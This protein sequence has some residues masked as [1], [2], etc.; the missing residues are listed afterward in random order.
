MKRTRDTLT[1]GTGDVNPQLMTLPTITLPGSSTAVKRISQAV[2]MPVNRGTCVRGKAVVIEVLKVFF[3]MPTPVGDNPA[4]VGNAETQLFRA[5]LSTAQITTD[6]S[7]G[8]PS[9]FARHTL[10]FEGTLG[11]NTAP[12][13]QVVWAEPLE[14]DLT[15]GA[16]HGLLI[17]TDKIWFTAISANFNIGTVEPAAFGCQI[18]YR[19]KT[20]NLEEYI[21]IVQS[22]TAA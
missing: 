1:G 7:L 10:N 12:V 19:F 5:L 6:N 4:S 14:V 2:N 8:N 15:D 17:A 11:G 18:L 13:T 21:G 9:V 16:G 20:V 3:D 22:Q